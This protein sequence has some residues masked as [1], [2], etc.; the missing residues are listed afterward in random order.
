M[1]LGAV[2]VVVVLESAGEEGK[3]EGRLRVRERRR[4]WFGS[5]VWVRIWGPSDWK[6]LR[7]EVAI[8]D[9]EMDEDEEKRRLRRLRRCLVR[10][11]EG[12]VA[13]VKSIV[14]LS[15]EVDAISTVQLR[16]ARIE[17]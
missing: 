14:A 16:K 11:R 3:R 15:G 8:V 12:R 4:S 2:G 6:R 13:V 9:A 10:G 5:R 17:N 1:A 7:K